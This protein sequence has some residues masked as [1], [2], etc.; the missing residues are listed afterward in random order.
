MPRGMAIIGDSSGI[1]RPEA[2][3]KHVMSLS[4]LA[5]YTPSNPTPLGDWIVF[6]DRY[7]KGVVAMR[8]SRACQAYAKWFPAGKVGHQG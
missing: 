1:E 4:A 6:A 7:R 2:L 8:Y 5:E 3:G